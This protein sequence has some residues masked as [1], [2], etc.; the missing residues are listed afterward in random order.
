MNSTF[1]SAPRQPAVRRAR[2]TRRVRR[3]NRWLCLPLLCATVALLAAC[4]NRAAVPPTRTPLPT[5]TPSPVGQA[6]NIQAAPPSGAVQ[7]PGPT[8]TST[9]A[10]IL[11]ATETPTPTSTP[12]VTNTPPPTNTPTA[13]AT[14]SFTFNLET[15]EKFPADSLPRSV[16][17]VY[18]Y[19]YSE[20]DLGLGDYSLR[21]THN[22][23]LLTVQESTT[24]GLPN[25]TRDE[26]GPYTRFTNIEVTFVETPAGTWTVQPV[27]ASGSPVA[28]PATFELTADENTRELY[29]RYRQR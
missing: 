22:D 6:A 9:P 25:Q 14:P 19:L 23:E 1:P 12:T 21:V 2:R 20:A 13:T 11:V 26:A 4:G 29:V 28:P 7:A 15:A 3:L 17:R 24:A 8:A 5:W 16:V 27:D 18:G 10:S